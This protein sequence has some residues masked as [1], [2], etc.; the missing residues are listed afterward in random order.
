[1]VLV[2]ILA[3]SKVNDTRVRKKSAR[4]AAKA[5]RERKAA[6]KDRKS[7]S[8]ACTITTMNDHVSESDE[9][10]NTTF[11]PYT[12]NAMN[13]YSPAAH[14]ECTGPQSKED[15]QHIEDSTTESSSEEE[16]IV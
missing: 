6:Q 16:T 5:E 11:P 7:A 3:Y 13:G 14:D 2:Q 8:E 4:A 15:V 10:Q 1:M 9:P 12:K